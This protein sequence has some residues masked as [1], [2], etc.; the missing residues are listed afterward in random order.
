MYDSPS[1]DNGQYSN[2]NYQ[3]EE[4][5]NISYEGKLGLATRLATRL[6]GNEYN[7]IQKA[8]LLLTKLNYT[9]M[10]S[11]FDIHD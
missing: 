5:F 2:C 9:F 4:C 1:S 3:K 8:K 10:Y 11:I 7:S 6:A